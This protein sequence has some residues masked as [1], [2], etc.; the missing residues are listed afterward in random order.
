MLDFQYKITYSTEIFM[1]VLIAG[2]LG[3]GCFFTLYLYKR[4]KER[5]YLAISFFLFV[6]FLFTI[7]EA[8]VNYF[9]AIRLRYLAAQFCR[10]EH[11]ACTL[12]IIALPWFLLTISKDTLKKIPR[13][14]IRGGIF[15]SIIIIFTAFAFPDLF[16]SVTKFRDYSLIREGGYGRGKTGIVFLF[17]DILF[18][19]NIVYSL[20]FM[21]K[22]LKNKRFQQFTK[23]PYIGIIIMIIFSLNDILNLYFQHN[24][25][26]FPPVLDFSYTTIGLS[27][28]GILMMFGVFQEFVNKIRKKDISMR[29]IQ[30][31]VLIGG[32]EFYPYDS[33]LQMS[34]EF[35]ETFKIDEESNEIDLEVFKKKYIYPQDHYYFDK[36]IGQIVNG[37]SSGSFVCRISRV[38]GETVWAFFSSPIIVQVSRKGIPGQI[39]WSVQDVTEQKKIEQTLS[40][41][42]E[43]LEKRVKERTSQLKEQIKLAKEL[44]EEAQMANKTKSEFLANMSHEIRTPLNGVMGMN[45]LLLDTDLTPEQ[46]EYVKNVELSAE[47]LLSLINDI[48]DISKIEAGKLDMEMANFN[49]YE[50]MGKIANSMVLRAEKKSL[51]FVCALDPEIPDLLIGDQGRLS[52]I[53]NNLLG[54]AFKFTTVGE[55]AIYGEVK[56]E[57]A[58]EI[59]LYFTVK[60]TGVGIPQQ[61]KKELFDNFTQIDSSSTREYGGTGLGLS[62]CKQL[63]EM[64]NGT[65]GVESEAGKGSIFWFT[66]TMKKPV[67]Q[68]KPYDLSKIQG[69]KVIFAENNRTNQKVVKR[70]LSVWELECSIAKNGLDLVQMLK[71]SID[72]KDFF[73]ILIFESRLPLLQENELKNMIGKYRDCGHEIKLVRMQYKGREEKIG[74][75]KSNSPTILL[76]PVMRSGL[77][78]CLQ[79]VYND[80]HLKD[81]EIFEIKDEE[82]RELRIRRKEKIL[83][84]E[85]NL[86]NQLVIKGML[87]K[88]GFSITTS[89]NGADA[90]RILEKKKFDLILMDIN[91]PLMDGFEATAIIRSSD[92]KVLEH[93]VPIIA[94][95]ANAMKGDREKCKAAGMNGYIAK[96][97]TSRLLIESIRENLQK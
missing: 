10:L 74:G 26:Y 72:S 35:V 7:F 87:Q 75:S 78:E 80:L 85:D 28:F 68:P 61:R 67:E 32:L 11:V 34:A 51:E 91:M 38:D 90:I 12:L 94:V 21:T 52:Q 19:L 42:K 18:Y 47:A 36:K 96:P 8:M 1:P 41:S 95:T 76:K 58:D 63:I 77:F 93:D 2:I 25:K 23:W 46:L 33:I 37:L 48:L 66:V 55:V 39:I 40:N 88:F 6:S 20:V 65:I 30:K 92:S 73:D 45:N 22:L 82:T 13:Y 24:R 4:L 62:I 69:K 83:I 54:N 57:T 64:M 3:L 71:A 97:V 89:F 16:V 56:Q 53:F 15:A 5:A 9:S 79:L 27:L 70:L 50:M 60:D 49:I 84:V 43:E 17:R 81:K 31:M 14:F 86:N 29:K 59:V 44:A